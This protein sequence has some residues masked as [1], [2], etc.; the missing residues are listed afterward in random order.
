MK[1]GGYSISRGKRGYV[2][3]TATLL[4]MS[5]LKRTL[6]VLQLLALHHLLIAIIYHAIDL[7]MSETLPIDPPYYCF[8]LSHP[9]A[10]PLTPSPDPSSSRVDDAFHPLHIVPSC[11]PDI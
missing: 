4:N 10:A 9:G 3:N 5:G 1:R 6:D 7:L 2:T 8:V 11:L